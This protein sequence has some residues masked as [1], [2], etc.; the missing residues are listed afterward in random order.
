MSSGRVH[1][2]VLAGHGLHQV[3]Q[4]F[5]VGELVAHGRQ[6]LRIRDESSAEALQFALR[7]AELPHPTSLLDGRRDGFF[8]SSCISIHI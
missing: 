5:A 8:P 4:L 3:R 1:E 7:E 6:L 2:R